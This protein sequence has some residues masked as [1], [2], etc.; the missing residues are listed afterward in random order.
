MCREKSVR[1][2]AEPGSAPLARGFAR[3]TLA[4]WVT[5]GQAAREDGPP[6]GRDPDDELLENIPLLVTELVTNAVRHSGAPIVVTLAAH[7]DR[8]RISVWDSDASRL[9]HVIENATAEAVRAGQSPPGSGHGMVVV[10]ALTTTWGAEPA[11][12][13][14]TVWCELNLPAGSR[15]A[16]PECHLAGQRHGH[17][18][19]A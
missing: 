19:R 13:G 11:L 2:P 1:L 16:D 15:L 7:A 4:A 8:F 5:A 6:H 10:S 14:K 17:A 18:A 3:R 9:P 12:G